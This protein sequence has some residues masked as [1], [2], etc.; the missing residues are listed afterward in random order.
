MPAAVTGITDW[1][2]GDARRIVGMGDL[3][4][5]FAAC[6]RRHGVPL[7]RM[8][9]SVQ[10]LHPQMLVAARQWT[11]EDGGRDV[12]VP[13]GTDVTAQY[14][15]SPIRT[16][17]EGGAMLRRRLGDADAVLDYSILPELKDQGISDYVVLPVAF[18][19]GRPNAMTFAT[20]AP[21]GFSDDQVAAMSA[22]VPV[23]A[24]LLEVQSLRRISRTVLET[25]LGAA[26]GPRV[27]AGTIQRGDVEMI[28]AVLWFCDLRGFTGLSEALPPTQVI[29]LL[30]GYFEAVCGALEAHGG[31]VLK[32]IGDAVLAIFP[33][34]DGTDVAAVCARAVAA[35]RDAVAAVAAT[36]DA[37]IRFGIALHLGQVVYG[38]IG[39]PDRL[40]FTVIGPPVNKVTRIEGLCAG[41]GRTLLTSSD[42][43]AAC[44]LPARPVGS[45]ALKGIA[46][47]ETVYSLPDID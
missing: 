46:G 29:G 24:P 18:S 14:L 22:A 34:G 36:G 19:D 44:G 1:L 20:R 43:A 35:S 25:Y 15:D 39:A 41:L 2:R 45:F 33:L 11:L 16:I 8:T 37:R 5:A 38:N 31:E 6:L 4:D 23:L 47:D 32:F 12:A 3:I 40:D 28:D 26:T 10:T 21:N 7:V 42:F 27:L 9:L 13:F 30:N 17:F